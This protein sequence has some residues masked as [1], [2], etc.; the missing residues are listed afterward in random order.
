MT[1]GASDRVTPLSTNSRS[2]GS[3]PSLAPGVDTT[4]R[5]PRLRYELLGCA[6]HGHELLDHDTASATGH[7]ELLYQDGSGGRF[8]WYRCL[9]CDAWAALSTPPPPVKNARG[10]AS[11]EVLVPLRGRPLRDRFVL[12]VIAADRVVHFLLLAA[13][14][15][16]IFLFADHRQTL[17]GDYTRI[18][19][20]LQ[21]AVGGPLS[22]S[23]HT[24][25]LRDVDR[26]FAVP[27]SRLYLYGA[28]IAV[29]AAINGVEAVG[30]WRARRWA[31]YLTLFEVAVLL[32][33]EIHELAVRASALKILTLLIN[34]AV[35]A[36]LLWAHRLLGLRG[37]GKADQAEKDRDTG[38]A[39][40]HRVTPWLTKPD[41]ADPVRGHPPA[42]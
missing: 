3:G 39:P 23:T 28:A 37:G 15:A 31:E 6:L 10:T 4:G 25:F 22:D 17:R 27:T 38:W 32:P 5:R 18:L 7:E 35:V 2:A 9:R 40:L 20:R 19:N 36:Y 30:L 24:G 42:H 33:I 12:R 16:I 34:L 29:Y 14:A 1:A 13:A 21:G 11:S 26:L 41:P 8:A